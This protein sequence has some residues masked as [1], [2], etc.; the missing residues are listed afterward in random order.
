MTSEILKGYALSEVCL[1]K[2]KE[3][4]SITKLVEVTNTESASHLTLVDITWSHSGFFGHATYNW[5]NP[6]L[7]LGLWLPSQSLIPT[8][9][10][11]PR[12][13]QGLWSA[14]ETRDGNYYSDTQ[15]SPWI[16][17]IT[18]SDLLITKCSFSWDLH[19]YSLGSQSIERTRFLSQNFSPMSPI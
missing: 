10:W 18:Y 4:M 2:Q 5:K 19:F 9:W 3:E 16:Q 8:V 6:A 11:L 12:P 7:Q 14:L 17:Q 15:L 1:K 13:L